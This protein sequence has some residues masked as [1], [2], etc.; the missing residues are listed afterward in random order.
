M[1]VALSVKDGSGLTVEDASDYAVRNVIPELQRIPGV[2]GVRQFGSEA[3]MRIWL[4][5]E[6]LRGYDLT[7]ADVLHAPIAR[8]KTGKSP[9]GSIGALPAV[10]GQTFSATI[11]IPRPAHRRRRI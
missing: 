11:N 1:V 8:T 2:G 4:N 5:P 6:K 7:A 9:A 10:A 3:S